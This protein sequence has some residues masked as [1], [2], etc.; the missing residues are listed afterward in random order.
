MTEEVFR[1]QEIRHEPSEV[2]DSPEKK[3]AKIK[4]DSFGRKMRQPNTMTNSFRVGSKK[5]LD[6]CR[7]ETLE[8][9]DIYVVSAD[10]MMVTPAAKENYSE[11]KVGRNWAVALLAT[12]YAR[13][14][15]Y[16]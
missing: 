11:G 5:I 8:I 7:S 15:Y 2:W 13:L 10:C 6:M 16:I 4:L 1:R 3:V 12:L 14:N 9:H